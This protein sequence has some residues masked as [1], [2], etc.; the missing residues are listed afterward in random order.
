MWNM[1]E[2]T[3]LKRVFKKKILIIHQQ[4]HMQVRKHLYLSLTVQ[5]LNITIAEQPLSLFVAL[6][7]AYKAILLYT[8]L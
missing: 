2:H 5:L 4:A 3:L 6:P 8:T 1:I 7:F